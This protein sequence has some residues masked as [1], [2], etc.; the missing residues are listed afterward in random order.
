MPPGSYVV[1]S[2]A[3]GSA[4]RTPLDAAGEVHIPSRPGHGLAFVLFD[5]DKGCYYD[6]GTDRAFFLDSNA[7]ALAAGRATAAAVE[8]ARAQADRVRDIS[9]A[10]ANAAAARETESARLRTI[11][12]VDRESEDAEREA[13]RR[14]AVEEQSA[15]E[16]MMAD[17]FNPDGDDA[18]RPAANPRPPPDSPRRAP[19]V[20]AVRTIHEGPS[21]LVHE[22][23]P[24]GS[25]GGRGGG[26]SAHS[27]AGA[28]APRRR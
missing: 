19:R 16:R 9:R 4:V 17:G 28:A 8:A 26:S 14:K 6:D 1:D 12:D 13:R 18:A 15:Y 25:R 22:L 20:H 5:A 24:R 11:V 2:W 7:S 27:G 10:E 3:T 23:Y 21:N